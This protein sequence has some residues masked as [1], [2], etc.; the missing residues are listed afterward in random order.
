LTALNKKI[1]Y[2]YLERRPGTFRNGISPGAL[3]NPRQAASSCHS[4][5]ASA[6]GDGHFLQCRGNEEEGAGREENGYLYLLAPELP[7]QFPG[8]SLTQCSTHLMFRGGR[9]GLSAASENETYLI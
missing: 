1:E 2:H 5:C 3:R 4:A 9:A 8:G 6:S 7:T